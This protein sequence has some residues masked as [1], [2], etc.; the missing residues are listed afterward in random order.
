MGVC[1]LKVFK[2]LL[3]NTFAVLQYLIDTRIE[4]NIS[5]FVNC[6]E[7]DTGI[8]N[9]RISKEVNSHIILE[10][11]VH[12]E[13][14]TVWVVLGLMEPLVQYYAKLQMK[15]LSVLLETNNQ[16]FLRS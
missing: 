8:Q 6:L 11:S 4:C 3:K 13:T 12:P 7:Y 5:T 2:V 14:F 1:S 9:Y 16:S 15:E 10:K